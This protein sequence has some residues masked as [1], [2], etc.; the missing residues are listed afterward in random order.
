MSSPTLKKVH[1]WLGLWLAAYFIL[2]ALAGVVL[3]FE[4]E[5]VRGLEAEATARPAALNS[6]TQPRALATVMATLEQ[7]YPHWSVDRINFP[8][9][10]GSPYVARMNSRSGELR[11]LQVDPVT[12]SVGPLSPALQAMQFIAD[13]H[14]NLLA[15]K[16]GT[17]LGGV[18]GLLLVA[19]VVTGLIIAWPGL[20]GL[21]KALRINFRVAIKAWYQLHR[22]TGLLLA[23]V[24][25]ATTLTGTVLAFGTLLRPLI[26][27]NEPLPA[28]AEGEPLPAVELLVRAQD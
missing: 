13:F 10:A 1:N 12:A 28:L 3:V 14:I 18:L 19:M 20:K 11:L 23:L 21:R 22:S 7:E 17:Y 6:R 26:V 8:A 9:R 24:I 4:H 15:G 16:A 5:I 2:Q 27:A 25:L